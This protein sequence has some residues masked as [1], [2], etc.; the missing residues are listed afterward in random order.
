MR[1]PF[2]F[3]VLMGF[4]AVLLSKLHQ[5][6]H[7]S[8]CCFSPDV[9]NTDLGPCAALSWCKLINYL[10][11]LHMFIHSI[12]FLIRKTWVVPVS[13]PSTVTT[14]VQWLNTSRA[15]NNICSLVNWNG[16]PGNWESIWMFSLILYETAEVYKGYCT[17]IRTSLAYPEHTLL[18]T[19]VLMSRIWVLWHKNQNP[20]T[21][22]N[23]RS[24][25]CPGH[26]FVAKAFLN[27]S[28][29]HFLKATAPFLSASV[30]SRLLVWFLWMGIQL[31]W[32]FCLSC[33]FKKTF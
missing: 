3:S 14:S 25:S 24:D 16:F 33:T 7:K 10:C 32:V 1:K 23:R 13:L 27:S 26:A 2:C 15:F 19:W 6:K 12:C 21:E 17:Q 28:P 5:R 22:R 18:S 30:F 29:I 20:I 4:D 11:F 9:T 8:S 31:A